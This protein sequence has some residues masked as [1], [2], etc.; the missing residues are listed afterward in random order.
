[1]PDPW[2]TGALAHITRHREVLLVG[3]GLTMVDVALS[4]ASTGPRGVRVEAI[5]RHGLLPRAHRVFRCPP[6]PPVHPLPATAL[7][8]IRRIRAHVRATEAAGGDWR[9]AIDSLR[10]S[11]PA[12]WRALPLEER[13]RLLRHAARHWEVHRHRMAPELD[14]RLRA[15]RQAGTVTI[16]RARLREAVPEGDGVRVTLTPTDP[17]A[18]AVRRV[19]L[20]VN[21]TGPCGDIDRVAP[22]LLVTMRRHGLLRPD[23]LHLSIDTDRHGRVI[24]AGGA[25][26]QGLYAVGPLRRGEG[27]ETTAVPEIRQHGHQVATAVL[28][29]VADRRFAAVV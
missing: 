1:M 18:P 26:V 23:P 4:L 19:D 17:S 11:T 15:L 21:C 6:S 7:G 28:A 2:A 16:T 5:S 14:R 3:T 13:R 9:G 10:S 20:V 25:P 12:Y 29:G 27:W 22:P 24:G 8:L